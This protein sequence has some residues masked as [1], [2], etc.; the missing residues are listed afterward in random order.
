MGRRLFTAFMHFLAAIAFL[1]ATILA[2]TDRPIGFLLLW[3][4]AKFAISSSFVG[5]FVYSSEIF[6]TIHRNL[7]MGICTSVSQASGIFAPTI[8]LMVINLEELII[9][10]PFKQ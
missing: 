1:F 6:P 9:I 3:L 5:L 10:L 4:L 7:C 2:N 8:R